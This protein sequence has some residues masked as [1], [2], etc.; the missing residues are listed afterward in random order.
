MRVVKAGTRSLDNG[1]YDLQNFSYKSQSRQGAARFRGSGMGALSCTC[2]AELRFQVQKI[3]H[4]IMTCCQGFDPFVHMARTKCG[5]TKRPQ[6]L[7]AVSGE[8]RMGS[9]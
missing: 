5:N 3:E 9:L 8:W 7:L 6:H 1:S 2:I 4:H